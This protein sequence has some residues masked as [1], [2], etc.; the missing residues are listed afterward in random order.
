MNS[1]PA[2]PVE[3]SI[4]WEAWSA[5][6]WAVFGVPLVVYAATRVRRGRRGLHAVCMGISAGV[7]VFVVLS[8]RFIAAPAARR[9]ALAALPIFKVHLAFAVAA[10]AGIAWQLASRAAPRLRRL[11]RQSGPY[12]VLVW[13]LALV[14]G[15]Y[16]FVF[17]YMM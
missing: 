1:L 6:G 9:Q 8:F 14:T 10:L 3:V 5:L 15:I 2:M 17:L 7:E 11:H 4:P 16:N 13:V 12:V